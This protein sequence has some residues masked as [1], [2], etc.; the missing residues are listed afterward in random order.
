MG[1][2]NQVLTGARIIIRAHAKFVARTTLESESPLA[3]RIVPVNKVHS[4]ENK[5]RK[6]THSTQD[7]EQPLM[8]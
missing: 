8:S 3:I 6:L 1:I 7:H 4:N 2:L 5:E